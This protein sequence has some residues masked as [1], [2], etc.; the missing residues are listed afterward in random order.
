MGRIACFFLKSS[1]RCGG[2]SPPSDGYRS[3]GSILLQE[4]T[5]VSAISQ[6]LSETDNGQRRAGWARACAIATLA[7]SLTYIL[8][9]PSGGLVSMSYDS[10]RYLAGA[11]SILASGTYLDISGAPQSTW[12]PGTSI[13]YAA[14]AKLSGRPPDELVKL[15]NLAALLL[16]VASLW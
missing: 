9:L 2:L 12:P 10:F 5:L 7:I 13:L 4:C 14:A 16:M 1:Q 8:I 6:Q 15:V 11:D 3:A